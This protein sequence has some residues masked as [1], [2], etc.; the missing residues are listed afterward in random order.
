MVQGELACHAALGCVAATDNA[1]RCP[2][3]SVERLAVN[4]LDAI[5]GLASLEILHLHRLVWAETRIIARDCGLRAGGAKPVA[6]CKQRCI[7]GGRLGAC[8]M[9]TQF[10]G[11]T[12]PRNCHVQLQS[13][14]AWAVEAVRPSQPG[15]LGSARSLQQR[16]RH[17][18]AGACCHG[19]PNAPAARRAAHPGER[20]SGRAAALLMFIACGVCVI[21]WHAMRLQTSA[22]SSVQQTRCLLCGGAPQRRPHHDAW[23][24]HARRHVAL[25]PH[26]VGGK[27]ET[28]GWAG[29]AEQLSSN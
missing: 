15:R 11:C 10:H 13:N 16:H 5:C 27:L 12:P 18:A 17:A 28:S 25:H 7:R 23:L 22:A 6:A 29:H 20:G 24:R 3:C 14:A 4:V 8:R 26:H 9:L 19:R 1:A 21:C 2:H